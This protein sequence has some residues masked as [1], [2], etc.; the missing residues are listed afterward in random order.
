MRKFFVKNE[1]RPLISVSWI[2][3]KNFISLCFASLNRRKLHISVFY[4]CMQFVYLVLSGEGVICRS[5]FSE[6]RL[7][8]M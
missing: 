5:I 2:F 3:I 6:T 8:N 4:C 7:G 1:R